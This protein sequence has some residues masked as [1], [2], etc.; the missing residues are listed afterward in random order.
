DLI[1][2]T[3]LPALGVQL[4]DDSVVRN[5]NDFHYRIWRGFGFINIFA[6]GYIF[7]WT[8]F[9]RQKRK[10]NFYKSLRIHR[11]RVIDEQYTSHFLKSVLV[12]SFG[13]MLLSDETKDIHIK[14]DIIQIL[15]YILEIENLGKTDT[16]LTS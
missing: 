11:E 1:I 3:L 7:I 14:S 5:Y 16:L 8:S 2:Y 4:Y 10:R 9:L 13:S 15:G 12:G 6:M